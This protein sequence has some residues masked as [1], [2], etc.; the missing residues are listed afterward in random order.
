MEENTELEFITL[1]SETN[2]IVISEESKG[3][4]KPKRHHSH[5]VY[6]Y[7]EILIDE[8][9]EKEKAKCLVRGTI[10]FLKNKSLLIF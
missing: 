7:F 8:K 5:P 3:Q 6:E 9:K 2:E 1:G 10:N 4:N